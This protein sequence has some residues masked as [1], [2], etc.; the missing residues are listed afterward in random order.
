MMTPSEKVSKTL[1][2]MLPL[3]ADY[4]KH[5]DALLAVLMGLYDAGVTDGKAQMNAL[6]EKA[7]A[8]VAAVVAA[9]IRRDVPGLVAALD[10]IVARC[11][12]VTGGMY[13]KP[14]NVH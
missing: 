2:E 10:S 3:L 7:A 14:N 12:P 13:I 4:A 1:P 6:V 9:H 11:Y 8:D 5:E